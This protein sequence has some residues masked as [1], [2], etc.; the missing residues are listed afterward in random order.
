MFSKSFGCEMI[1]LANESPR[2][3]YY[4]DNVHEYIIGTVHCSVL[5]PYYENTEQ[6]NMDSIHNYFINISIV[7]YYHNILRVSPL[8]KGLIVAHLFYNA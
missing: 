2:T 3:M 7:L 6:C 1:E 8:P 4:I 5:S